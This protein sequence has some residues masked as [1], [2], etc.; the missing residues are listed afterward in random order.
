MMRGGAN[1]RPGTTLNP[2]AASHFASVEHAGRILCNRCCS[3]QAITNN[4]HFISEGS[5]LAVFCF[6]SASAVSDNAAIDETRS[7]ASP[8]HFREH[9]ELVRSRGHECARA[10]VG[11]HGGSRPEPSDG[12]PSQS[13]L[14]VQ[15]RKIRKV[16]GL[17][18]IRQQ[19]WH[20]RAGK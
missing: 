18:D 3:V 11:D 5:R 17:Y 6:R 16:A 8:L 1:S 7:P 2:K 10:A 19:L 15:L 9:A 12:V 20:L 14:S 4:P 13:R